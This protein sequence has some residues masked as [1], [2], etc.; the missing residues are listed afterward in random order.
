MNGRRLC[1]G[2][3]SI[4]RTSRATSLA[5]SLG[6]A[7]SCAACTSEPS[8]NLFGDAPDQGAGASDGSGSKNGAGGSASGNGAN[9]GATQSGD[10]GSKASD[11]G[12]AT[13][14]GATT[15]GGGGVA[16]AGGTN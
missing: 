1:C 2:F 5:F 9:G 11:T 6:L 14:S 15:S 16:S 13:S 7:L 3:M 8:K 12:G 4:G 10:G